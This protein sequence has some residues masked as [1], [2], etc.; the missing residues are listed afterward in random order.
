MRSVRASAWARPRS[1]WHRIWP[2]SSRPYN[3]RPWE[4][5]ISAHGAARS[6]AA[7]TARSGRTAASRNRRKPRAYAPRLALLAPADRQAE[8]LE[9]AIEVGT[10]QPRA[11]G[12]ARHAAVL[13]RQQ[14]LEID[15]LQCLASF[16][17]R[18][19]EG[20][21]GQGARHGARGDH[22]LDVAELDLFFERAEREVLH[23][24]FQLGK[25]SRPAV[26]PQ[27]IQR[28]D[29]EAPRGTNARFDQLRK[30]ERRQVGDVL[31][32]IA[33]RRQLERQLAQARAELGVEVRLLRQAAHVERRE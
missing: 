18:A 7:A 10:L 29:G 20:D 23:H 24:A 14:V 25:V 21:L 19:V 12:D 6:T 13:A 17:I 22:A 26:V 16:A 15:A 33:H 8:R 4:K 2:T 30:H 28:G 27:R 3:R 9:L 11:L 5:A 31:G 32:E 1:G